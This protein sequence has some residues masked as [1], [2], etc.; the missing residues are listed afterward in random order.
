MRKLKVYA[1]KSLVRGGG[2]RHKLKVY[3]TK[4]LV[5]GGGVR[6]KLKVYAT[7]PRGESIAFNEK[8][9]DIPKIL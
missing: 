4:S 5:R 6:H 1:T 9:F 2:V 8:R 7:K 3:A